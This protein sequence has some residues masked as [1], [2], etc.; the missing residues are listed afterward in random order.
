MSVIQDGLVDPDELII[1]DNNNGA[2][3]TKV[4][5]GISDLNKSGS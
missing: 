3:V 4:I 2:F 5:P 1:V